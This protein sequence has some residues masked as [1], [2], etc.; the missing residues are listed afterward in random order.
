[1]PLVQKNQIISSVNGG[2]TKP[3]CGTKI[4]KVET[5]EMASKLMEGIKTTTLLVTGI[6]IFRMRTRKLMCKV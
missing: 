6:K 4:D 1:M 5:F 3:S 2:I